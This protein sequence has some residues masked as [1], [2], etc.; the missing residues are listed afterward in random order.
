MG[1]R[2]EALFL[3]LSQLLLALLVFFSRLFISGLWKLQ[4]YTPLYEF[5]G[6]AVTNSHK[7]VTSNQEKCI[8]SQFWKSEV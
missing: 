7:L 1:D 5:L 2:Y 3:H 8:L 4:I 6:A